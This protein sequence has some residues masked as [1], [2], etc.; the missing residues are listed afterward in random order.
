MRKKGLM[1]QNQL[2]NIIGVFLTHSMKF[3]VG[4]ISSLF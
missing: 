3:I 4:K 2:F 1:T